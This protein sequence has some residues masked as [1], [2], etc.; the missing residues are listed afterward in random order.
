MSCRAVAWTISVFARP[1]YFPTPRPQIGLYIGE[2]LS[3][4]RSIVHFDPCR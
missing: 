2:T 1:V 3:R 4:A